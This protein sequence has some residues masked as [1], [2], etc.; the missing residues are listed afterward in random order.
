VRW[1][2]LGSKAHANR[3]F[4]VSGPALIRHAV[5]RT[6]RIGSLEEHPLVVEFRLVQQDVRVRVRGHAEVSLPDELTDPCPRLRAL[7]LAV[8]DGAFDQ[9]RPFTDVAPAQPKGFT[10]AQS[11]V[12][13]ERDEG[14]PRGS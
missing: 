13:K 6:T 1:A 8:R 12:R 14:R 9:D 2:V 11:V 7:L 10:R 5:A 3:R 4:S